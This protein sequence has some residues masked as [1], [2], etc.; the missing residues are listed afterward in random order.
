MQIA[1]SVPPG[2][3]HHETLPQ[4]KPSTATVDS[5]IDPHP[6]PNGPNFEAIEKG[7]CVQTA[8]HLTINVNTYAEIER[9]AKMLS[10]P[11]HK[12]K[13]KQLVLT[14][15][16]LC[17]DRSS[18]QWKRRDAISSLFTGTGLEELNI[19]A[20][21]VGDSTLLDDELTTWLMTGSVQKLS[22]NGNDPRKDAER[23]LSSVLAEVALLK[24]A[25]ELEPVKNLL[26]QV[27]IELSLSL[28]RLVAGKTLTD[29]ERSVIDYEVLRSATIWGVFDSE[30]FLDALSRL[31]TFNG[32]FKPT[33]SQVAFTAAGASLQGTLARA[34]ELGL[35][36]EKGPA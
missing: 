4:P 6:V 3:P 21:A 13:I 20:S 31:Q 15:P 30:A 2:N 36:F 33:F 5:G 23:K 32:S 17:N 19:P 18:N 7:L 24:A 28:M 35:K 34:Q 12:G 8:V 27:K 26:A 14:G 22:I 11:S 10:S 25:L 1:V 29:S 16:N 9:V